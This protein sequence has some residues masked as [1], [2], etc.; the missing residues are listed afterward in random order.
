M[1]IGEYDFRARAEDRLQDIMRGCKRQ[2][3]IETHSDEP[4]RP[5]SRIRDGRREAQP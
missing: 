4:L 3:V 1:K 5:G 2:S